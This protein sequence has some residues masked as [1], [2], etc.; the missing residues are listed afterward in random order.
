MP[1]QGRCRIIKCLWL[2]DQ[3]DEDQT[4]HS[5]QEQQKDDQDDLTIEFLT[6]MDQSRDSDPGSADQNRD[7]RRD[8]RKDHV[9]F[10]MPT[11]EEEGGGM[12]QF[13]A[14]PRPISKSFQIKNDMYTCD[15]IYFN[16]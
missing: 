15:I 3:I 16:I 9:T 10:T 12:G 1:L 11:V 4:D 2:H 5:N 6:T 8:Q 14:P 13:L 7:Q